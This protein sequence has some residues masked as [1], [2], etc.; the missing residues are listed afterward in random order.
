[1]VAGLNSTARRGVSSLRKGAPSRIFDTG[2]RRAVLIAQAFVWLGLMSADN[3]FGASRQFEM[4]DYFQIERI[5]ELA[6]SADGSWVAYA[7]ERASLQENRTLKR[8][9]L[10]AI[11][12]G[13]R[14][15]VVGELSDAEQ[16]T[17]MSKT[18]ELAYLSSK[19][20][21]AQVYAWSPE[22]RQIRQITAA[23]HPVISFR[24]APSNGAIAYVTRTPPE[25]FY[26]RMRKEGPGILVDTRNVGYM[27]MFEPDVFDSNTEFAARQLWVI[28]PNE[29][30]PREPKIPGDISDYHWSTDG[31]ALSL[32]YVSTDE[33]A[34]PLRPWR[35]SIG[36]VDVQS[37][38][39][40]SVVHSIP[41]GKADIGTAFFGGEWIPNRNKLVVRRVKEARTWLRDWC[42]PEVAVVDLDLPWNESTTKWIQVEARL[43]SS[44]FL[45]ETESRIYYETT[46]RAENAL[47]SV[48][49]ERSKQPLTTPRLPGSNSLF[50][51]S[52]DFQTAS[53]V[54]QSLS[55][56][57]EVYVWHRKGGVRRLSMLNES[58]KAVEV[59]R[60]TEVQWRS[61]DGV[62]VSGW[63]LTP[64]REHNK[65]L[66]LLTYIHGGPGSPFM[67]SF[68]PLASTWLYPVELYTL[69]GIAVFAP[70]YRGTRSFGMEFMSPTKGDLEPVD[71]VVTGIEYLVREGLADPSQL[72]ISGHSHGAWLGPMIATRTNMF[73]VASFAEGWSNQVALY[74]MHTAGLNRAVH[75]AGMGEESLFDRPERYLDLSPDLHFKR[76]KAATLLE[77]GSEVGGT[78]QMLGMAKAAQHFGIPSEFVIYPL[79]G[80]TLTSPRLQQ[81]SAVRN[82]DWILYWLLD[83]E[84]S[85]SSKQA[86]YARWRSLRDRA[87]DSNEQVFTW[88]DCSQ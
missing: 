38:A 61:K 67:N 6:L 64:R 75:E 29:A 24:I 26:T 69:N 70:N 27:Q 71:D 22:T 43:Y 76:Y 84:D 83:R 74:E 54:S 85:V 15:A 13:Q 63:L 36:I 41:R 30:R 16:L 50:Q 9:Y 53:F 18:G 34:S 49:S 62:T 8:V 44:D 51:F 59:P 14:A 2:W 17:W 31:R 77:A 72:A 28:S 20:G 1:M 55:R 37:L 46:I 4:G 87:H 42:F 19:S 73:K 79:A 39:F 88:A 52:R 5:I 65:P 35:T 11:R 23:E 60:A 7:T 58:L 80:H 82:L 12:D 48:E 66:P 81:E 32:T 68:V 33:P 86:Q 45:P 21:T 3:A 40:S 78:T 56:P 57:P 10:H 25:S 47:L